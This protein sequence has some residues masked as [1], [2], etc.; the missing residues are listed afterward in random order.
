M[1]V[2]TPQ[3]PHGVW[4]VAFSA[5][6]PSPP[7]APATHWQLALQVSV[8]VPQLYPGQLFL[9]SLPLNPK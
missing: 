6:A 7:H 2:C 4:R 8:R 9:E 1:S 3:L 5:Q